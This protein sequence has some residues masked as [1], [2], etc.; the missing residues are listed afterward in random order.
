M[1]VVL[2]TLIASEATT[3]NQLP[4]I[5]SIMLKMSCGIANGTSSRQNRIHGDRRNTA[6][7]LDEL[8][9]DGAQRLIEAERHVPGLARE[10]R[11]HRGELGAEHPPG[12]S[13]MKNTTVTEMKPRIG[14]DCRMSSSG[15]STSSACLFL[16]AER[17][18]GEG[19]D[20]REHQ[21]RQHAQRG[22]RRIF[23][24]IG[25]IERD[26]R[27][28]QFG[29]WRQQVA[30]RFG[31]E[32]HDAEHEEHGEQVPAA[33]RQPAFGDGDRKCPRHRFLLRRI[34][35]LELP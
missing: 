17:R 30:A 3:K 24:K 23:R 16:A 27:H 6:R 2:P 4:D 5:E 13:D 19:E 28:L 14:T 7:G 20:E 10:D 33:E 35:G 15:T 8:D 12:A 18:I 21:R 34:P 1:I 9:R 31:E 32:H 25:R 29:E 22:A 26:R 11:E